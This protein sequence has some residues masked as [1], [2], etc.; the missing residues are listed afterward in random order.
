MLGWVKVS[1]CPE[2]WANLDLTFKSSFEGKQAH[3]P[4]R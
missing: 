2:Q 3:K 1:D 4:Q